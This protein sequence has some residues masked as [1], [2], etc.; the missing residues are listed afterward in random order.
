MQVIVTG[1]GY[2]K[3]CKV[4]KDM[5]GKELFNYVNTMTHIDPAVLRI[6]IGKKEIYPNR[7]ILKGWS[8]NCIINLKLRLLGGSQDY[9]GWQLK[10]DAA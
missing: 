1:L 7:E 3:F 5:T 9:K 6:V 8:K 10:N 2:E 4:R